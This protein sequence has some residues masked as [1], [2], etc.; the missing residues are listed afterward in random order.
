MTTRYPVEEVEAVIVR[1]VRD[2]FREVSIVPAVCHRSVSFT[3]PKTQVPLSYHSGAVA[4]LA[5]KGGQGWPVF[6]DEGITLHTEENPVFEGRAPA[7]TASH[8]C[9]A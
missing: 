2:S 8:E 3:I 5:E 9:V 4:R 6:F 7:V 1:T